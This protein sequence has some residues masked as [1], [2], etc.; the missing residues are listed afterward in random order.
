MEDV[1][2]GTP[3]T[4]A[5]TEAVERDPKGIYSRE[6]LPIHVPLMEARDKKVELRGSTIMRCRELAQRIGTEQFDWYALGVGFA[7]TGL[8]GFLGEPRAR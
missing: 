7:C 8:G 5:F 3:D 1:P 6:I 4:V 2:S